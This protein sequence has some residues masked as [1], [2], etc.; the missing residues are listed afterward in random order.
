MKMH[1]QFEAPLENS[2]DFTPEDAAT[3][4]PVATGKAMAEWLGTLSCLSCQKRMATKSHAH[5]RL[6]GLHYSKVRLECA[7]GHV[8]HRVFRLDWLKGEQR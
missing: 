5:K 7:D 4:E 3:A 1:P 2:K 8:E 6:D